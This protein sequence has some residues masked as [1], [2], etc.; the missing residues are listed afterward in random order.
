MSQAEVIK[1]LK[2]AKKP[3]TVDEI[4]KELGITRAGTHNNVRQ[5]KK[6]GEV[7][8]RPREHDRRRRLEYWL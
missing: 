4:A 2:R 3:M 8:H 7:K 5:L 1:I 6:H